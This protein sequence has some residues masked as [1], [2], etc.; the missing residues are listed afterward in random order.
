MAT[1]VS[2]SEIATVLGPVDTAELGRTYMHEH[3][4]VLTTEVQQNF[5]DEWGSEDERV[6]DAVGQ[7]QGARRPRACARSSTRR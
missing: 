1:Y 2:M 6:A 3:V 7:A 5:P 4:F